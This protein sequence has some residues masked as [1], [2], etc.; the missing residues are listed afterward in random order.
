M[1][2]AI[3]T[4][5]NGFKFRSRV[6]ARWAVFFDN[7]KI[8]YE[9]EKEGY[10]L[11]GDYYLPDFWVPA[12]NTFIEIKG[13]SPTE[14]EIKKAEK[15][16]KA[17]GKS[18]L[19]VAGQPWPHEYKILSFGYGEGYDEALPDGDMQF[20]QCRRCENIFL[21][22][23]D[24]DGFQ[25]AGMSIGHPNEDPKCGGCSDRQPMIHDQIEKAFK[26]AREARF[27]HGE[28]PETK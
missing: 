9:Y 15:L 19:L 23:M 4:K 6:E 22:F 16:H 21:V 28:S 10:D 18:V 11:G 26:E 20:M 5:Y 14:E 24:K 12:W 27:E 3:E 8:P 7:I 17:S 25:H 13:E 1:I 2:K